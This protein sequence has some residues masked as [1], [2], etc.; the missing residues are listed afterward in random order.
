[1]HSNEQG[2]VDAA[3]EILDVLGPLILDDVLAVGVEFLRYQRV[4]R[5]SLAGAVAVHHHYLGR[6]GGFRPAD[7]GVYLT[8]VQPP[9]LL[10]H[11][12]SAGD[13]IEP[14]DPS[15]ALHVGDD[16]DSHHLNDKTNP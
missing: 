9:A 13:L 16:Q 6:A 5:P 10:V 3:L 2:G 1:M 4:E 8:G 15:H 11:R 14:N 7:R 12:V